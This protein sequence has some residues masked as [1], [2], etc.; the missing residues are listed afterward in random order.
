M[1]SKIKSKIASV[2]EINSIP[3]DINFNPSIS[4]S[5]YLIRRSILKGIFENKN[6]MTGK[7]LD[8][9]CGSKPYKP[10]FLKVTDYI[11]LDFYNEGHS[12]QNEEIDFF[13]DGK[14]IPFDKDT[15]DSILSTEVFEHIFNLE[16]LLAELNRVLKLN[17]FILITCP[18]VYPEHETP[19]DYARYTQ[20]ALKYLLE[21]NGFEITVMDKKGNLIETICQQLIIYSGNFLRFFGPLQRS[22][23][24]T[25]F[26]TSIVAFYLNMFAKTVGKIIP[27]SYHL[28][29]TNVVVA[30]KIKSI[31]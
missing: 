13:Y 28:Y 1:L 29:S 12:H 10:V 25:H 4:N 24:F 2:R 27:S 5:Y 8:F 26:Y 9:G 21:K 18:F 23:I 6:F 30:K 16:E 17:G 11:G 3:I 14:K 22:T 19:F 15:F 20:F 7:L 31:I